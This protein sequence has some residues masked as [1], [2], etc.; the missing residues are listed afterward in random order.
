MNFE[1]IQSYCL[2]KNGVEETF[3][4]DE[5]T[6]VW[7]VGGKMFCLGDIREF[8]QIALKCDPEEALLLREEHEQITGAFHM[9]KTHWNNVVLDGFSREFI[10]ELIDKSYHLVAQK[11]P[12]K[13]KEQIQYP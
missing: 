4:F 7:K 10:F 8:D 9:N 2:S 3:P 11:L 12:K 5:Y 6:V 13:I 1:L